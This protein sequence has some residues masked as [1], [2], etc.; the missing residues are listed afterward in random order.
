MAASFV[1]LHIHTEYSLLDG[2]IR[3]K[4]ML[5]K[6]KDFDMD[7]I[8][9][10]DHGN[11]FGVVEFYDMAQKEGIKPII[12]CEVYVAP[13][14]RKEKSAPKDG[15][16]TDYHLILLVTNEKGYKNLCK[17][18]TLA[19]MEGFYYHPRIDM[20]LLR[21]YNEGLIA[22]SACLKGIIPYYIS[23][24]QIDIAKEKAM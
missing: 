21:E 5:K 16:P 18:V 2:A 12:G 8:A 17:L 14:S 19:H 10:T 22:F 24:E 13:E 3:I 15:R 11:M 7:S 4:D 9:I 20:E 23:L 1:H 6:A